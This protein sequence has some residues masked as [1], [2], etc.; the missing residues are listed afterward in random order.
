ME[1]K[2]GIQEIRAGLEK[3]TSLVGKLL[4]MNEKRLVLSTSPSNPKLSEDIP[5]E[6]EKDSLFKTQA[7]GQ[8]KKPK[9]EEEKT[10]AKQ[11]ELKEGMAETTQKRKENWRPAKK[12]SK[13]TKVKVGLVGTYRFWKQCWSTI[14][15]QVGL[16]G[17]IMVSIEKIY[18]RPWALSKRDFRRNR[19]KGTERDLRASDERSPG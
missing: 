18:L 9:I 1:L 5:T 2:Q 19:L 14:C 12:N 11:E 16:I 7:A 8:E 15:K 17:R 13:S 3:L 4:E 6:F 10:S